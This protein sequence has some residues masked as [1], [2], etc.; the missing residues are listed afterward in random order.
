MGGGR[1]NVFRNRLRGRFE[2]ENTTRKFNQAAGFS[3]LVHL[4]SPRQP[5]LTVGHGSGLHELLPAN[6][7]GVGP[8]QAPIAV[9]L[10][11][12]LLAATTTSCGV[13]ATGRDRS[14]CSVAS[15]VAGGTVRLEHFVIFCAE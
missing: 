3:A 10:A 7:A 5:I 1:R 11:A 13:E 15:A 2:G 9:R 4:S 14:I 6:T 8:R 12:K